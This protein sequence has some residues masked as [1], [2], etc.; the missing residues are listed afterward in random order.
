MNYFFIVIIL[1]LGAGGYYEYTTL[2]QEIVADQQNQTDL[3]TRI[4]A[5]QADNQ[6]LQDN[7]VK[8]IKS[9]ADAQAQAADLARQLQGGQVSPTQMAGAPS[10]TGAAATTGGVTSTGLPDMTTISTLDGKTYTACKIL[11]LKADGIII[12]YSGGITEIAFALMPPLLQK[13]F[14]YDPH[15]AAAQTQAQIDYQTQQQKAATQAQ[16]AGNN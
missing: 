11:K 2:Q 16:S 12:S 9:T 4:D 8:L 13:T 15:Q 5:L 6:K 14:G 1:A 3:H 7:Q 10:T